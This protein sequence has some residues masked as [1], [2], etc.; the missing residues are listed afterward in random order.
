MW[1]SFKST[2]LDAVLETVRKQHPVRKG[3]TIQIETSLVDEVRERLEAC[4]IENLDDLAYAF[5]FFFI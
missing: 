2:R 5:E 1:L 4:K 3:K